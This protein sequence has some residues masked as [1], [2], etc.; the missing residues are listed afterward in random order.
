MGPEP[1][2]RIGLCL[3]YEDRHMPIYG[4]HLNNESS[5]L[6]FFSPPSSKQ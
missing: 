5:K 2:M 1:Q 3:P 6:L 4:V